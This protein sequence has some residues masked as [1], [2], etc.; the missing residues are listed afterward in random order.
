MPLPPACSCVGR[1]ALALSLTGFPFLWRSRTSRLPSGQSA[2]E[3]RARGSGPCGAGNPVRTAVTG[4]DQAHARRG[5]RRQPLPRY[6]EWRCLSPVG[7]RRVCSRPNGPAWPP[8]VA[9]RDHGPAWLVNET[10]GK[11]VSCVLLDKQGDE[12]AVRCSSSTH[13][14]VALAMLKEGVAVAL[15]PEREPKQ[16]KVYLAAQEPHERRSGGFGDRPSTCRGP[17]AV[18]SP[19]RS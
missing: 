12:L 2:P 11:W 8:A 18:S 5:D 13:Q 3:D 6:R 14:D 4:S 16:V 9:V 15:P 10:L 1:R 17:I 7:R 19:Q